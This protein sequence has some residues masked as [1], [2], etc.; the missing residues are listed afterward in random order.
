V[1]DVTLCII[2]Y[3]GAEHLAAAVAAL[4]AQSWR[5]GELL[6]VDNASEDDSR[7][8]ARQLCPALR[9]VEL[10]T[11]QGPGAARNAGFA[12]ASHDLILF[13]DN[14]VRLGADTAAR[15]VAH[16]AEHPQCLAVAPRVLYDADPTVVQFDSAD[17]HYLGFMATRHADRPVADVDAAAAPTTSMVSACFLIDRSLWRGGSPFDDSLGFNLEDHDFGVR[18]RV[19]GHS[20]WVQPAAT[21]RH[22]SGTPGLSYRPGQRPTET[23]VF[24]LTLNRWLIVLRCYAVRTLVLLSPAL[25]VVELMQVIWLTSEGRAG[26]WWRAFRSL[27]V[28]RRRLLDERRTI[29]RDRRVGDAEVLRDGPLPL[30][31]H[32]R[33]GLLGRALATPADAALRAYWHAVRRWIPA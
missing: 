23:R 31:R 19:A 33:G 12:A 15:L 28:R 13:Q 27:L 5:F 7:S 32:V 4:Q 3:N 20:L 17:C 11:N 8:L 2:N 16:L 26:V 9:I 21:V 25:L 22:G 30:T 1:T 24:Y 10:P 6:L 18:A 14:D 29:Q